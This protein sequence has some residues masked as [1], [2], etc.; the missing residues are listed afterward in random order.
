M[1]FETAIPG[2]QAVD[3][4]PRRRGLVLTLLHEPLAHFLLIGA[5]I[6]AVSHWMDVTNNARKT[7]V[8]TPDLRRQLTEE[9]TELQGR[10]P[11]DDEYQR[12]A[13]NWIR[14][15]I[16]FREALA[17]KLDSG[18]EMI[19]ERVAQKMRLLV[20]G[21]V[22]VPTPTV[23]ELRAWFESRRDA[24]DIPVRYDFFEVP[25]DGEG[26][27][28]KAR[29]YLADIEAGREPEALR[30]RARV[31]A[32]RSSAALTEVFGASFATAIAAMPVH[33]WQVVPSKVGWHL[34][35]VDAVHPG[36]PADFEALRSNLETAWAEEQRRQ[37]AVKAM[38]DLA[39]SYDIR[40]QD[41][42]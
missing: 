31:F 3:A 20:F 25:I 16:L 5:V 39:A 33:T 32:G 17:L 24:Y 2:R 27:E 21:Q 4:K 12:A 42:P 38:N 10:A 11:T 15:E 9:F 1:N 37:L 7:I 8:I 29:G 23:A 22:V 36:Q 41:L 14:N 18:D 13:Q 35:R 34:I 28:A 26:A 40:R 30:V 6:F 19:R